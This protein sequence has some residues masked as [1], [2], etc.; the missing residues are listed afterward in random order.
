MEK[1]RTVMNDTGLRVVR[2]GGGVVA[3]PVGTEHVKRDFL[4]EVVDGEPAELVWAL[5]PMEVY[6]QAFLQPFREFPY[7][8]HVEGEFRW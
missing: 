7:S 4:Q 5:I 6:L 1:Q 3:V 8:C 2:H